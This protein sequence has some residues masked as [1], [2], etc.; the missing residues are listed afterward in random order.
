MT[1][2]DN[3]TIYLIFVL[4]VVFQL[5]HFIADFP[6]QNQYMLQK[7]RSDWSFVAPLALHCSIHAIL[8]LLIT[9][10]VQPSLWWLAIADFVIHFM[11][12]RF[13]AGPRYLG[14]FSNISKTSYW[15]ALG[16]D[17]MVHH[18]THIWLIWMLISSRLG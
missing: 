5:K 8:T 16:F 10:V 1:G 18:L 11:M 14:R 9:L 7:Q 15:A 6:L 2:T 12:D 3:E 4:L 13:K 17:Q